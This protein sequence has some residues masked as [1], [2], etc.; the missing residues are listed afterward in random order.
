M[1]ISR[2]AFVSGLVAAPTILGMPSAKATFGVNLDCWMDYPTVQQVP[3]TTAAATISF[4]TNTC[5]VA[6]GIINLMRSVNYDL[7]TMPEGALSWFGSD[8]TVSPHWY[9]GGR[10]VLAKAS[11]GDP[12]A[13]AK[14]LSIMLGYGISNDSLSPNAAL[15]QARFGSIFGLCGSLSLWYQEAFKERGYSVRSVVTSDLVRNGWGDDGHVLFEV[16]IGGQWRMI[17]A[18]GHYFTDSSGKHLSFYEVFLA[19]PA[20]CNLVHLRSGAYPAYFAEA[21]NVYTSPAS[22][23]GRA[24]ADLYQMTDAQYV[25]WVTR[26]IGVPGMQASG[27]PVVMYMPSGA[28]P[29][30]QAQLTALGFTFETQAAWLSQWYPTN[31]LNA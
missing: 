18:Y 2:R 20:N 13:L 6:P 29:G 8:Q 11:G 5:L 1:K 28:P 30:L 9:A 23:P 21:S 27:G 22:W 14:G 12:Y 7:T 25:A 31:G 10:L 3:T 16:F 24:Y 17:D 19:G 15:Y 4:P 26:M